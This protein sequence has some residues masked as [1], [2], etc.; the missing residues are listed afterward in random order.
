MPRLFEPFQRLG[1]YRTSSNGGHHGLGLSIV[2][3]IANAHDATVI[4]QPG[5]HGGLEV[6]I[7]FPLLKDPDGCDEPARS[8]TGGVPRL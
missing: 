8:A 1:A 4:A 3:A 5:P 6:R 7:G 2:H